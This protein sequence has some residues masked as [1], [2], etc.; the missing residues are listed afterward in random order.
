M[1]KH[2]NN[3]KALN[4]HP[5]SKNRKKN[6]Q[7]V[8]KDKIRRTQTVIIRTKSELDKVRKPKANKNIIYRWIKKVCLQGQAFCR[9]GPIFYRKKGIVP[10]TEQ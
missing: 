4:Q 10:K 3:K 2:H 6:F 5:S 1:G 7:I 9:F 8:M